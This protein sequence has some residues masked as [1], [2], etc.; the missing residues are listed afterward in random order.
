[1]MIKAHDDIWRP[2]TVMGE[3]E[4]VQLERPSEINFQAIYRGGWLLGV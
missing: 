2:E 3:A 4:H 1:M